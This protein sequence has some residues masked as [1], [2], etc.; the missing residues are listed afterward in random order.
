MAR[1]PVRLLVRRHKVTPWLVLIA[2]V[3]TLQL[4]ACGSQRRTDGSTIRNDS[5]TS[6]QTARNPSPGQ[7]TSPPTLTGGFEATPGDNYTV[8]IDYRLNNIGATVDVSNA[9][10]NQAF[11]IGSAAGQ[12]TITNTTPDRNTTFRYVPNLYIK[13]FWPKPDVPNRFPASV[14]YPN[15]DVCD[16]RVRTVTYCA[17]STIYFSNEDIIH[18]G[19]IGEELTLGPREAV[20]MTTTSPLDGVV[21]PAGSLV[22]KET[23]ANALARFVR[24]S[25][26]SLVGVYGGQGERH[27]LQI[28]CATEVYDEWE[29]NSNEGPVG[30]VKADGHVLAE[31]GGVTALSSGALRCS[32]V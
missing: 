31:G 21:G 15:Y 18:D 13:L 27:T 29:P 23:Y 25:P 30:L 4:T 12:L 6:V 1:S 2:A 17:L 24:S 32:A 16:L 7:T 28:G 5:A 9:K 10:P 11:V 14:L 3:S 19:E 20:R 22:V 26:P 8:A